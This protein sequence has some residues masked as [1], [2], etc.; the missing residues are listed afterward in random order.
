MQYFLAPRYLVGLLML[1]V[2]AGF[3]LLLASSFVTSRPA[4]PVSDLGSVG[5]YYLA[6]N[7]SPPAHGQLGHWVR[8]RQP[9]D[10]VSLQ[11]GDYWLYAELLVG[12]TQQQ[13][14]F[15]ASNSLIQQVEVR[16]DGP[17]GLS[18]SV[19]TG[20][21]ASH[22]FMLHYGKV[23]NLS[24][25]GRYEVLVRFSSPF[26]SSYPRFE[27][28]PQAAYQHHVLGGNVIALGCLGALAC[29]AVFNLFLFLTIRENSLLYYSAYLLTYALGWAFVFNLPADLFGHVDLRWNYVPFFL[30][31]VLNT[32]FYLDFLNIRQVSPRLARASRINI[33]LPL[34][35][36]PS[37][38]LALPWAHTLATVAIAIWLSLALVCG[39]VS[40]RS[41]YRPARFFVP[42]FIALILPAMLILP[43]N[44]GLMPDLVDNELFTLLGG[45]LDGILLAFAV[46]DRYRMVSEQKD[47]FMHELNQAL[48][49]A[50]TDGLTGVG[51]RYAFDE[52]LRHHF[53]FDD[54]KHDGEQLMVLIDLDGLKPINDR[55]GHSVGDDLLRQVAQALKQRLEPLGRI[56]RLGGDEF[57]ILSLR[58]Q[59]SFIMACLGE[60]ERD[61][62]TPM[63]A[64]AGISFGI[65]YSS[66]CSTPAILVTQADTRMYLSKSARKALRRRSA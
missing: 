27:L 48:T 3:V 5:R 56:Y 20:Y 23:V 16:I 1:S 49:L 33:V 45:T 11:G 55:L 19:N 10:R 44:I 37:C 8:E 13:W 39:I 41:G 31:P 42:A 32:L 38:F 57:A 51:N 50:N 47:R 9:V 61:I 35:L 63:S 52:Y 46:A 25:P 14:V 40:W 6:D 22:D 26:F 66:E 12:D 29:L 54:L 34:L 24:V 53:I 28:W 36:L 18:Q 62:V 2:M 58:A 30:L 65:A 21:A 7:T 60:I 59:E 4:V 64:E 15:E 17:D 43:A